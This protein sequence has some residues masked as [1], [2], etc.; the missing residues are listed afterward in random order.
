M[1]K[2]DSWV[3]RWTPQCGIT[4]V[5][6]MMGCM[7]TIGFTAYY[8]WGAYGFLASFTTIMT[9]GKGLKILDTK[10]NAGKK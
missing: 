10:L 5:L 8:D 4:G 2:H 1:K 9:G 6:M 7:A 3:D